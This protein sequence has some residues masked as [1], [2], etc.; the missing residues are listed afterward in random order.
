MANAGVLIA[1][2]LVTCSLSHAYAQQPARLPPVVIGDWCYQG[3]AGLLHA[4]G[5]E[6]Q[7]Y[8]NCK[9]N[10]GGGGCEDIAFRPEGLGDPATNDTCRLSCRVTGTTNTI[11]GLD[12]VFTCKGGSKQ[13]LLLNMIAPARLLITWDW[14]GEQ[15]ALPR[16][17][18][19]AAEQL[20]Q[21]Y[22][23]EKDKR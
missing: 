15:G 17:K 6:A 8:V 22:Y 20:S 13:R 18:K 21:D 19:K 5:V 12:A 16:M 7:L 11:Y 2:V 23:P 14:K 4:G 10:I 1:A 9:E 3:Q